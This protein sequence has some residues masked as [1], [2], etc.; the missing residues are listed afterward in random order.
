M[1]GKFLALGFCVFFVFGAALGQETEKVT[2][3]PQERVESACQSAQDAFTSD[4]VNAGCNALLDALR[5]LD[6][7][8]AELVDLTTAPVH[9]LVFGMC[10]LMQ[11]EALAEFLENTLDPQAYPID[12]AVLLF[13]NLQFTS[14]DEGRKVP[15][16]SKADLVQRALRMEQSPHALVRALGLIVSH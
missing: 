4:N 3:L 6:P 10:S 8:N 16:T 5:A 11:D 14:V 7:D 12:D 9:L 1:N 15:S 13:F 2:V